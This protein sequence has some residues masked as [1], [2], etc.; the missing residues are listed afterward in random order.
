MHIRYINLGYLKLI[1]EYISFFIYIRNVINS[2]GHIIIITLVRKMINNAHG[3][4]ASK[5]VYKR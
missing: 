3:Y 1:K 5:N 2:V 4:Q